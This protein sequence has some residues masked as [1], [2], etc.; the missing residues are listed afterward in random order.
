M[1]GSFQLSVFSYQLNPQITSP[2]VN[3]EYVGGLGHWLMA[4][5]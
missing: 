5:S 3:L 2:A 1:E 4:D